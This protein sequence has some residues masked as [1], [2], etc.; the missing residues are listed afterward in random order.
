MMQRLSD[1]SQGL[2]VAPEE[3]R[4]RRAVQFAEILVLIRGLARR[5]KNLVTRISKA[6]LNASFIE[7]ELFHSG[8]IEL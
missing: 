6:E 1:T 5:H 3:K 7:F 8:E 4:R 2:G